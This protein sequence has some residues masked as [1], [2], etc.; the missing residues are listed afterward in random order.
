MQAH[1]SHYVQAN[2]I[3]IHGINYP[4]KNTPILL[5][6]GLTANAY[7]FNG[8]IEAGLT[9]FFNVYSID[10]R[11][12]GQ[13]SKKTFGYSIKEHAADVIAFLDALQIQTIQLVGHSFG[14]LMASYLAYNFPARF[15][16]VAIL[17]AAPKMNPNAAQMLMPALARIDKQYPNFDTY[18]QAIKE[19]PYLQ[20]WE[21]AMLPYYKADVSTDA[22]GRVECISD[23]AD[24]FQISTHVGLEP[25]SKYFQGFKQA[26]QL[27]VAVDNYTLNQPILPIANAKNTVATMQNAT[28]FQVSGN[29]QTMLF[30]KGALQIVNILS[31]Q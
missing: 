12:R 28:Y 9:K 25:W 4:N 3:T 19:A 1:K 2:D 29:H 8:L 10:F 18:L 24:I 11:G 23:I 6:H 14:G 13:S 15:T 5:M 16:K 30:G 7:A 31:Q 26:S 27:I 20:F 21:P 17:D 22:N